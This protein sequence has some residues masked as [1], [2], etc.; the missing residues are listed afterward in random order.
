MFDPSWVLRCLQIRTTRSSPLLEYN[1]SETLKGV[2]HTQP[3]TFVLVDCSLA[4]LLGVMDAFSK[5]SSLRSAFLAGASA[6]TP[7]ANFGAQSAY[8]AICA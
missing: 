1:H 5:V 8:T 6:S 4:L 3:H 2:Y 7:N